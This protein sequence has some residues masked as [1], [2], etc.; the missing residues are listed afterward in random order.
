MSL[1]K[2]VR[3]YSTVFTCTLVTKCTFMHV[4]TVML[5]TSCCT[6][7]LLDNRLCRWADIRLCRWAVIRQCN[8]VVLLDDTLWFFHI[9]FFILIETLM[10]S[11][12][13]LMHTH[14]DSIVSSRSRHQQSIFF[15]CVWPYIKKGSTLQVTESANCGPVKRRENWKANHIKGTNAF[16]WPHQ[17]KLGHDR[18][19]E[20]PLTLLG[21]NY[22]GLR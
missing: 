22:C 3:K 16:Q 11:T 4:H 15:V 20:H 13:T 19:W 9:Y 7:W 14:S 17:R 21:G 5:Y 12:F 10:C 18:V 2:G 6:H 1:L 8:S